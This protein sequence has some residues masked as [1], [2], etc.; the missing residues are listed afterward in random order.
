MN[1]LERDS[2]ERR[3][4][5]YTRRDRRLIRRELLISG[6]HEKEKDKDKDKDMK[7]KGL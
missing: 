2:Q 1:L 5:L 7:G 6:R 3:S 4:A